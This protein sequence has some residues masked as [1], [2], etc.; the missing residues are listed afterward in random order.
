[1]QYGFHVPNFGAFAD[2]RAVA[3]LAAR[4][5]AC[6]WDGF[7]V[8]DHISFEGIEPVA[9]PWMLLTA[10]ALATQRVRIGPM[11]TS[12]PRR[13]AGKLAREIATLDHLSGGRVIFGAG[14]GNG[15]APESVAF[16]GPSDPRERAAIV[17]E[18]LEVLCQWWGEGGVDFEGKH[19][20]AHLDVSGPTHQQ[21]RVPIW[22]GATWPAKRPFRRASAWEGVY[23]MKA[24]YATGGTPSPDETREIVEYVRQHRSATDPF[25]VACSK[26]LVTGVEKRWV[27]EHA[28]A[29]ATWFMAAVAPF[30]SLDDARR[31]LE[32]GPP[33]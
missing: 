19:V 29:G 2:V 6:G 18:T 14:A 23:P 32:A 25:D 24:D 16:G 26:A 31:Y 8:W 3:D 22:L 27:A 17:E 33:R 20:R 11:V 12:L 4:A 30:E 13:N 7:F 1:M 15:S 10:V 5:E 28:D 9:D 21:P